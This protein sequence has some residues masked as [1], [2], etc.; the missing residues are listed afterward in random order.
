MSVNVGSGTCRRMPRRNNIVQMRSGHAAKGRR[1]GAAQKVVL[2]HWSALRYYRLS[3]IGLLPLPYA[4]EDCG[5]DGAT[6]SLGHLTK[7]DLGL[8]SVSTADFAARGIYVKDDARRAL[9]ELGQAHQSEA[10][11]VATDDPYTIPLP[12]DLD[13]LVG[14]G[15]RR[16]AA[17]GA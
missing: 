11:S 2:S 1:G 8:L 4:C 14:K 15:A 10:L 3:S 12:G 5:L 16:V 17:A 7:K 13:V 6:A 9:R